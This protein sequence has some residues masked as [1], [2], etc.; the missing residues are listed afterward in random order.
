MRRHPLPYA[1]PM[2]LPLPLSLLPLALLALF[3]SACAAS[4]HPS[5]IAD[6]GTPSSTSALRTAA[7]TP[8]PIELTRV[9]AADWAVDRAG[10]INLDHPQ[11]EAAGLEDGDE[12]IQIYAYVIEHPTHGR[13][14]IDSGVAASFRDRDTAPV[15]GMVA[16]AMNFDALAVHVDTATLLTRIGPVAG[17]FLTH[18]HL[19][20]IMGLPDVPDAVPVYVGPGEAAASGFLN[21]FTQGTTDDLIGEAEL[22]HWAFAADPDGV[23]DGVIDVFGDATVFAIHAPGH[24]PGSTAFVVRTPQGPA[25]LVGDACHTDWGWQHAVEPGTFNNDGEQAAR[26]LSRLQALARSIPGLTVH[27]GH[28][29]HSAPHAGHSPTARR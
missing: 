20:H 24:T 15:S 10:L 4:S 7:A 8:G 18:L 12:P 28:Q 9:V 29:P 3:A 6:R 21:M 1:L 2:A 27:L 19:D 25:L 14:L 11:A 17:V 16:S 26:S 23:V 13:F 5:R 22:R